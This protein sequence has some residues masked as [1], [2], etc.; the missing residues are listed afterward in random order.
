MFFKKFYKALA[1]FSLTLSVSVYSDSPQEEESAAAE[2]IQ[3]METQN[4]APTIQETSATPEFD[5][6]KVSEAF[7]HLIGKNIQTLG[8]K[9]DIECLVKGLKD[10]AEGKEYPLTE[11]EC[12]QA[13]SAA[14]EA[15]FKQQAKDNLSAAVAF[16]S[17]NAL[18]EDVCSLEE[19]KLQY[20]VEKAGDGLVTCFIRHT[21]ASLL[22][23]ENADPDVQKDLQT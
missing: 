22:I 2:V 1:L 17:K 7:G 12:V 18:R 4:P 21:S 3:E 16:L 6:S 8:F 5:V 13:L 15:A 19:G 14:Q 20:K 10:A 11:A 23:Q 9:F